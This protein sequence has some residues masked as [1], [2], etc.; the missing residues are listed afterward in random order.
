MSM[1]KLDFDYYDWLCKQVRIPPNKNSYNDLFERMHNIEYVWTVPNDNNRVQDGLDLRLEC[2]GTARNQLIL[3]GATF[4]EVLIALSRRVAFNA[5]GDAD[6]WAWRLIKHIQLNKMTD[7]LTEER[8]KRVDDTLY[9]VIWRL[10][11][12]SGE[13]GFFPLKF[14]TEDQTKVEIWYQMQA[15]VIETQK[16]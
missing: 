6:H 3:Q 11:K 8:A 1:T 10:Y 16:I 2:L 13:G 15:Y 12:P 14:P 7:P 5:G 9:N 4:L